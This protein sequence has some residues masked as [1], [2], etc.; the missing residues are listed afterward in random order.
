[1][2][3]NTQEYAWKNIEVVILGRPVTG[4]REVKYKVSQEKEAVYGRGDQ[5]RAIQKGNKSYDGT[6]TLLQSEIE[7]LIAAAGK[8]KNI[9]D[10]PA[11]DV[12]VAYVPNEIGTI[13]TDIIKNVEI[14]EFEKGMAQNDKFAEISLPFI[15][16]GVDFNV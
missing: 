6:I 10:L 3:F 16:L 9:T 7:A 4:I 13:V 2:A 15:A 8:G 5:P 11:F 1:M 12:V 14:T